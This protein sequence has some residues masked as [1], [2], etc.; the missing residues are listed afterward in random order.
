MKPGNLAATQGANSSSARDAL[1][2]KAYG[3]NRKAACL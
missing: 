1:A 2:D 3:M